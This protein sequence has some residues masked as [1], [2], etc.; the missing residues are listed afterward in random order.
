MLK[1]I[2]TTT[3]E[4]A[5]RAIDAAPPV[6]YCETE[7]AVA[8]AARMQRTYRAQHPVAE[9]ATEVGAE[10]TRPHQQTPEQFGERMGNVIG[11]GVVA[12]IVFVYALPKVVALFR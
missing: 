8:A 9:A 12:L 7:S 4:D 11:W 2:K 3:P 5:E 10:P 6:R 1:L